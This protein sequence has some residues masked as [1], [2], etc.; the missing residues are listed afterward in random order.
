MV[1]VTKKDVLKNLIFVGFIASLIFILHSIIIGEP[2]VGIGDY[3]DQQIAFYKHAHEFIRNGNWLWDW[4]AELGTEFIP[5][6]SFYLTFSP[7]F[8]I[9]LL[10]PNSWIIYLM[11]IL[12]IFKIILADAAALLF[13][14]DKFKKKELVFLAAFLY[15]F[16]G[17]LFDSLFFNHF[18]EVMAVFPLYLWAFDKV[19]TGE[20]KYLFAILTTFSLL[21]NYF[22]WF[23]EVIFIALYFFVRLIFDKGYKVTWKG[24]LRFVIEGLIGVGLTC[25]VLFPIIN[26]VFQNPRANDKLETGRFIYENI[27]MYFSIIKNALQFPKPIMWQ[28]DWFF[29]SEFGAPS[30]T[31]Y[32]AGVGMFLIPMFFIKSKKHWLKIFLGLCFIFAMVPILNS[33]FALFSGTYYC[34][35]FYMF[36]FFLI[37]ASISV[38]DDFEMV[39]NKRTVIVS[40]S[41]IFAVYVLCC[42]A[43]Y[44]I[45]IKP[46][47]VIYW[48]NINFSVATFV[49]SLA[50]FLVCIFK[51]DVVKMSKMMMLLSSVGILSFYMCGSYYYEHLD[52]YIGEGYD[53]IQTLLELEMDD[54]GFY[55]IHNDEYLNTGLLY[56]K[57]SILGYN[58]IVP[59]SV[60]DFYILIGDIREV[61][62]TTINQ[63]SKLLNLFSTKYIYD[64]QHSQWIENE[65]YLPMGVIFENIEGVL[66][67]NKFVTTEANVAQILYLEKSVYSQYKHLDKEESILEKT[68]NIEI[69]GVNINVDTYDNLV[70]YTFNTDKDLVIPN[71]C[72]DVNK[73][74]INGNNLKISPFAHCINNDLYIEY[75][76]DIKIEAEYIVRSGVYSANLTNMEFSQYGFKADSNLDKQSL[77]FFTIPY[78]NLWDAYIDGEHV[79]IIK[80]DNAFIVLDIP[81]GEHSI[82]IIYNTKYY[83]YGGIVTC[84]SAIVFLGY[85]LLTCKKKSGEK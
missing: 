12:N 66:D 39:E 13:F 55:R 19:V 52:L 41:T 4:N 23:G 45:Y 35:W 85:I 10:F 74:R 9:T 72:R 81:A 75:K 15:A 83:K 68:E 1:S 42:I 20:K 44:F 25:I 79:E 57:S 17:W 32:I 21:M 40:A 22:F 60:Y 5:T 27:Q 70:T 29:I 2:Y 78:D 62:S 67:Y 24:F 58:S 56:N 33:S 28:S 82:E 3:Y 64:Y 36:T 61:K 47:E 38:L 50:M 84:A 48:D 34:R 54:E 73:I 8:L 53:E 31:L 18:I 26:T 46:T 59:A 37:W 6:Y 49:L 80:G 43:G 71:V 7:F 76:G 14:K 11:P 30:Q 77:V 51:Q 63:N 69:D 65:N 16:C